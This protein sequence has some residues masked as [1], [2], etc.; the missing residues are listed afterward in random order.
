MHLS[1]NYPPLS[2]RETMELAWEL[3][4]LGLILDLDELIEMS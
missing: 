4:T 3:C 2:Y 1:Y